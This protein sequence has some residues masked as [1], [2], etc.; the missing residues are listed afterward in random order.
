MKKYHIVPAVGLWFLK[1]KLL[2]Q[3]A[4]IPTPAAAFT[5]RILHINAWLQLQQSNTNFNCTIFQ[6]L[7]WHRTTN[8]ISEN[9]F[10][11]CG[12]F[13][14]VQCSSATNRRLQLHS[15]QPVEINCSQQNSISSQQNSISSQTNL[16][17]APKPKKQC[18]LSQMNC[19]TWISIFRNASTLLLDEHHTINQEM[20]ML[21]TNCFWIMQPIQIL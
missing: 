1:H 8:W 13:W 5:T 4:A 15:Y 2:H 18:H 16:V 3:F 11:S 14:K 12:S 10:K 6:Q 19:T 21:L 7:F 9:W 20:F 17:A